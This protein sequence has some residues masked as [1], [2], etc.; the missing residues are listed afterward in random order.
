M[1]IRKFVIFINSHLYMI[2]QLVSFLTYTIADPLPRLQ[3]QSAL[4]FINFY[5][6]CSTQTFVAVTTGCYACLAHTHMLTT[7]TCMHQCERDAQRSKCAC[8]FTT[9]IVLYNTRV[10]ILSHTYNSYLQFIHL[11]FSLSPSLLQLCPF[12][13]NNY[14]KLLLS[15]F[16]IRYNLILFLICC[17]FL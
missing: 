9:M 3:F 17:C 16:V 15:A 1:Y 8:M 13:L 7:H 6:C 14:Y 5:Y 12:D 2:V 4:P 11:Y 10:L